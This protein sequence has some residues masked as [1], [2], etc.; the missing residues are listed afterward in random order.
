VHSKVDDVK[1]LYN[2]FQ[3]MFN[4]ETHSKKCYHN[5]IHAQIFDHVHYVGLWSGGP[6]I[7]RSRRV[8]LVVDNL[9]YSPLDMHL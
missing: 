5:Q 3:I 4:V 7:G 2:T 8:S 9:H 6:V 1:S